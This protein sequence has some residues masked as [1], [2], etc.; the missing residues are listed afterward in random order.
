MSVIGGQNIPV[1]NG[2]VYALDF[3]NN[4]CYISGSNSAKSLTFTTATATVTGSNIYQIPNTVNG[5]LQFNVGSSNTTGSWI[6]IPT[7]FDSINSLGQFTILV[8]AEGKNNNNF[9]SDTSDTAYTRWGAGLG[10]PSGC[11][12]LPALRLMRS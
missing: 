5:L 7:T 10:I 6:Q 9:L 2:L 3:K 12:D 11:W 4:R 8:T 1:T